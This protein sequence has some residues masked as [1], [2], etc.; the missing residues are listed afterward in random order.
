MAELT[1]YTIS[2]MKTGIIAVDPGR[3]IRMFND[4]AKKLLGSTKISIGQYLVQVSPELSTTLE[5]WLRDGNL[6]LFPFN[7]RSHTNILPQFV[8]IGS[9]KIEGFLIFLEDADAAN[10]QAQQVKLAAL[11][12]LTAGIAHEIRNP[13]GA[14]SHA[15]ELLNESNLIAKNDQ[16][17]AEIIHDNCFRLN[18]IVETILQL[19]K[20][21]QQV[22]SESF[23]LKPW[24]EKFIEPI[25]ETQNIS[26][27]EIAMDINPE[28]L[29]INFDSGH[30]HQ[31]LWNL[32]QNGIR[33]AHPER[34]PVIRIVALQRD[35]EISIDVIDTGRGVDKELLGQLFEPFFT[36]ESSGTGLGLY[37]SKTLAN[38][39]NATLAYH[40]TEGDTS[41]FRLTMV[42][43]SQPAN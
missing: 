34:H 31:I 10:A 38:S 43:Q 37:I 22:N 18:T 24:L 29:V 2:Q 40:P 13:L 41:C 30:L 4:A 27:N 14:I 5:R 26:C 42:T 7:S 17:L 20:R 11:G 16:R 25:C 36:T 3:Q 35:N 33:Y 1:E 12:R 15:S 8:I 39:N 32:C 9:H 21:G 28:N 19:G 23:M 6:Q